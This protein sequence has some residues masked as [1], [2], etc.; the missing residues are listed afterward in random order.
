MYKSLVFL[1]YTL[2][3]DRPRVIYMYVG[4]IFDYNIYVC[5]PDWFII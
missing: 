3:T 5:V 1:V 2:N 4:V